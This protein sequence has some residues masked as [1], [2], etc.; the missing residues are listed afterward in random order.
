MK[1]D[2]SLWSDWKNSFSRL[3]ISAWVATLLELAGPFSIVAAQF[4]YIGAPLLNHVVSQDRLDA[5]SRLLEEPTQA[6]AFASYLR[7][8]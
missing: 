6:K 1:V 2:D 8:S 7:E 5:F 3:G 4:L